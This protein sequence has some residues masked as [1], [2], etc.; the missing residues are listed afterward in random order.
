MPG[1]DYAGTVVFY[2]DFP[3]ALWNE[4]GSID[5]LGPD[6]FAGLPS[7][8]SLFPA[9][10]DIGDQIERKITGISLYESQV[11]RLFD[12]KRQMADAVRSYGAA[13]GALGDVSGAAERYWRTSRV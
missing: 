13:L 8:V 12:D 11:E 4:F 10:T 6:V 9:F 7:G 1:P 5:Q 3:Y 2:E